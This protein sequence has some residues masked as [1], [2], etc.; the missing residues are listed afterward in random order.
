MWMFGVVFVAPSFNQ[1][2][3]LGYAAKELLVEHFVP[4]TG[5]EGGM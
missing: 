1:N 5:R 4:Q 3:G 2:S